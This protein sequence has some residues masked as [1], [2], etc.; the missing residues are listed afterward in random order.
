MSAARRVAF[1]VSVSCL[2]EGAAR[3][4]SEAFVQTGSL[5]IRRLSKGSPVLAAVSEAAV[6]EP[7][8]LERPRWAGGG[9]LSDL[10]NAAIK[11]P[12]VFS[13]M[14]LGARQVLI[15]TAEDAGIS[16]SQRSEALVR[17]ARESGYLDSLTD[18]TVDYPE[19][20]LK[21]FHA[22]D[23][24]NLSWEAAGECEPAT[25]SMSQRVWKKEKMSHATS[26]GRLRSTF[27]DLLVSYLKEKKVNVKDAVDVGCS[28]GMSTLAVQEAVRPSRSMHGVDLSPFFLAVAKVREEEIA[29]RVADTEGKRPGAKAGANE[30]V[31]WR[32]AKAESLPFG[33]KSFDLYTLCFTLHELPQEP[34]REILREAFRVTRPGGVVALTDND[35]R[36][37]VIQNLPPPL[38]SLMKSTEPWSDQ[39]YT[40]DL[41]EALREAGFSD[42]RYVP[43][44]PRHRTV[45]AQRPK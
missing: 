3:R 7:N 42:V 35:P 41:E 5:P 20:Y 33:S 12:A 11:T 17:K 44:D 1:L 22:Y 24:G 30:R 40:F 26:H 15:K 37:P 28:V 43:S 38:F 21:E 13:L 19:Y 34:T 31:K 29:E 23:S 18:E 25:F 4:H 10:V 9:W 8:V 2:L 32:H 27:T 14:K 36:S 16:W 6:A 45:L 39:Y